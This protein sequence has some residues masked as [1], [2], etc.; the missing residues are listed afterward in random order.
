[1]TLVIAVGLAAVSFGLT[2]IILSLSVL[3]SEIRQIKNLMKQK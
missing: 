3:T 1:M 2:G